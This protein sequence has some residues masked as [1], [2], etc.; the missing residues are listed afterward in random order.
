MLHQ[1]RRGETHVRVLLK[2]SFDGF[3][4]LRDD[5]ARMKKRYVVGKIDKRAVVVVGLSSNDGFNDVFLLISIER[6]SAA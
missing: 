3:S 6:K 4:A 5:L 2:Q 1:I